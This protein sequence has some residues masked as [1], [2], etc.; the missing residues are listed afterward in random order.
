MSKKKILIAT[1]I[2]T[3]NLI[4]QY[5]TSVFEIVNNKSTPFEV[6]VFWRRGIRTY[7]RRRR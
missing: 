6:N 5:V 7:R 1:P 3:D 2:H 4:M